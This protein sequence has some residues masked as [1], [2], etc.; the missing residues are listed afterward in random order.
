MTSIL[1]SRTIAA[2]ASSIKKMVSAK[3]LAELSGLK[4]HSVL[5]AIQ[6]GSLKATAIGKVLVKRGTKTYTRP[7]GYKI[8]VGQA[9]KFLLKRAAKVR[10]AEQAVVA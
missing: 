7:E 2:R 9:R 3:R 8:E 4:H 6:R 1:T 10:K 5:H